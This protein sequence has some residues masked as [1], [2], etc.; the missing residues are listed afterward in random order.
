MLTTNFENMGAISKL[1]SDF[2]NLHCYPNPYK[3]N[4]GLGHARIT[5]SRLTSYTKVKIYNI[6]GELVY[7][8]EAETPSGELSWDVINNS[9]E[10]IVSGVYIYAISNDIGHK[11]VGKFAVIR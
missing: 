9:G 7:N 4:S 11:K 2:S 8:A 1:S 6:A 10:K 5:F 3:P